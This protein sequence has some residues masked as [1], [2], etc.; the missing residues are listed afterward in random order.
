MKMCN[1]ITQ[2]KS[3]LNNSYSFIVDLSIRRSQKREEKDRRDEHV[4]AI[5]SGGIQYTWIC[6]LRYKNT[7]GG[8]VGEPVNHPDSAE[9][10]NHCNN[11][12]HPSLH[13]DRGETDMHAD[14]PV[15]GGNIIEEQLH[16]CYY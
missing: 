11:A 16:L 14:L 5:P 1:N 7:P 9:G 12:A 6:R 10:D 2:P 13:G 15:S 4:D 3:H 8:G